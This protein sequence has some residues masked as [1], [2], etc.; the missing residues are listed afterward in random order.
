MS[1]F[2]WHW[3]LSEC[4]KLKG[5]WVASPKRILYINMLCDKY[6]KI[7]K[8]NMCSE[9]AIER[10]SEGM[11]KKKWEERSL[12]DIFFGLHVLLVDK[13]NAIIT[14]IPAK[15]N[16]GGTE[17]ESQNMLRFNYLLPWKHFN[18]MSPQHWQI[19]LKTSKSLETLNA[20]PSVL[21]FGS[22]GFLLWST[23]CVTQIKR[24]SFDQLWVA[25]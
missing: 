22:Y 10:K 25:V 6:R 19:D 16:G 24:N 2:S 11:E 12:K 9:E 8:M 17:G 5:M 4:R 20:C 14:S 3:V 21:I 15:N 13:A 18:K 7:Q 1:F 23:L